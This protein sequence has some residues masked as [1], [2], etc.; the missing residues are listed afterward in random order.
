[1]TGYVIGIDPGLRG[2]IAW[3]DL[4][5]GE[6]TAIPMPATERDIWEALVTPP[7]PSYDPPRLVVI[8]CVHA[9]PGDGVVSV[10]TFGRGYGFLRGCVVGAGYRV[11]EVT[12]SVWQRELGCL[13]RGDKNVTKRKAQQLFPGVPKITH[14]TAD[15]L[16]LAEYARR[17]V[18]EW[19]G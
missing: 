15:A 13:T 3:L 5:T 12:P 17:L 7:P 6:A 2:G 10:F 1:M 18:R 19:H 4:D 16:L 8:E 11:E 14:K 9:M